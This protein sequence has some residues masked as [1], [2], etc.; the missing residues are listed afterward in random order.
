MRCA[1]WPALQGHDW[2]DDTRLVRLLPPF[3]EVVAQVKTKVMG[4]QGMKVGGWWI[5]GAG[6]A[7]GCRPHGDTYAWCSHHMR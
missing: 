7:A 5:R 6:G 4:W 1:C 2:E 3:E